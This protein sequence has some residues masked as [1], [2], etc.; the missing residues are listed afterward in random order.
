MYKYNYY[1]CVLS[2][3]F[4]NKRILH[5]RLANDQDMFTEVINFFVG[6]MTD[7]K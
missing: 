1:K 5:Y 7:S 2:F 3:V 6:E 4:R